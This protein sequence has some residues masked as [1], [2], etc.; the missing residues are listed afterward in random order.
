MRTFLLSAL[1]AAPAAGQPALGA[2]SFAAEPGCGSVAVNLVVPAL[3]AGLRCLAGL[4]AAA[5][6]AEFERLLA[7]GRSVALRC[8]EDPAQD[9]AQ[10][11]PGADPPRVDIGGGIMAE[12]RAKGPQPALWDTVFHEFVHLLD[13][14]YSHAYAPGVPDMAVA[15]EACCFGRQAP[16]T[17]AYLDGAA[18]T[19]GD[20][21]RQCRACLEGPGSADLAYRERMKDLARPGED[22]H[23]LYAYLFAVRDSGLAEAEQRRR[24]AGPLL[25]RLCRLEGL[26]TAAAQLAPALRRDL[27]AACASTPRPR[28]KP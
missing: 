23:A 12:L 11:H 13:P 15:C 3:Q 1:L 2:A 25:P 18:M 27:L 4:G 21:A 17:L 19:P 6:V 24:L 26:E 8:L 14:R 20:F 9:F 28:T 22:H 16:E 7:P 10:A 5:R